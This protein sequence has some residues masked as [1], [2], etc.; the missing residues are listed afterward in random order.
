MAI[1]VTVTACGAKAKTWY[2]YPNG[3]GSTPTIQSAVDS[4]VS[5]DN[6]LISAGTYYQGNI[7]IDG[8]ILTIDQNPQAYL[9]SPSAGNGTGMTIRNVAGF[10]LNSLTFRGFET[11]VAV[12]NAAASI[13][14]ITVKACTRGVTISGASSAPTVWFCLV[15][16][17]GTGIEVQGG[18]PIVLRNETIV[19][20][21]TGVRFLGGSTTFT[22]NIVYNAGTGIQ[23]SG[24]SVDGGCNDFYLNTSN[25]GGCTPGTNDF[26]LNPMFCFW[27]PPA[28]SPYWLHVDSPCFAT[29]SNPCGVRT[30]AFTSAAGC[31]GTA[32]E[33]AT[34]GA[35][36]GI[37]R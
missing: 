21:S 15:D 26:Y 2:V 32:T 4:A 5:G 35:I 31:S 20:C 17:C 12:E 13:Q 30:G 3:S 7:V 27:K 33:H 22:R 10:T 18:G 24:G 6:I 1:A 19:N 37:Y 11:A 23:C 36:K 9:V 14:Y 16:S 28:P 8:K 29:A 34:W 25:Y